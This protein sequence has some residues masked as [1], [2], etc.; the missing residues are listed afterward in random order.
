[1]VLIK[2]R[3]QHNNPNKHHQATGNPN[4]KDDDGDYDEPFFFFRSTTVVF[5]GRPEKS[6]TAIINYT[7]MRVIYI[8][9]DTDRVSCLLQNQQSKTTKNN[10]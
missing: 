8:Y 10:K 2:Q 3:N 7:T 5:K 9:V 1:M 4:K 6:A